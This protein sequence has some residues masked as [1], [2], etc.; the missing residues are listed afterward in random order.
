[1]P[2]LL[3]RFIGLTRPRVPILFCLPGGGLLYIVPWLSH[4]TMDQHV[5]HVVAADRQTDWCISLVCEDMAD[6]AGA[7]PVEV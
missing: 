7:T 3:L 1:M 6:H 2:V 5:Q 4:I